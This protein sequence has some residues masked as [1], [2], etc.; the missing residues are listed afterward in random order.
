MWVHVIWHKTN[1]P[2]NVAPGHAVGLRRG[3][4]TPSEGTPRHVTPVGAAVH[5][6]VVRRAEG[7]GGTARGNMGKKKGI[8]PPGR[9]IIAV[10]IHIDVNIN[11]DDY[12][13]VN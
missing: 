12:V 8:K 9:F 6:A 7:R 11:M 4:E 2:V 5:P 13:S 3:P 1:L 10:T